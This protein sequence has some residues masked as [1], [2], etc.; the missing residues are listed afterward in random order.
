MNPHLH[1]LIAQQHIADLRRKASTAERRH[2]NPVSAPRAKPRRT[3][4]HGRITSLIA[5]LARASH[6][7]A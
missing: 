4:R 3:R 1:Y 2:A 6:A 5:R 7:D